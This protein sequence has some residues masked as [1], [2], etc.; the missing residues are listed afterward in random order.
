VLWQAQHGA[1]AHKY[2]ADCEARGVKP[3]AYL[4]PPAAL[5]GVDVWH[6]AFWELSTER[7]FPGGPI[8]VSAID[9]WPVPDDADAFRRA[10]RKADAAYLEF[11]S[12]P[13]EERR[14]PEPLSPAAFRRMAEVVT[15]PKRKRR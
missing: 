5:P 15:P 2:R 10:I 3:P 14:S 7:R 4:I 12:R 11:V 8:P 6:I 13:P 1:T 9:A